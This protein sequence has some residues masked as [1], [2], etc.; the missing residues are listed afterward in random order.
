M[1]INNLISELNTW[2]LLVFILFVM[3]A[4]FALVNYIIVLIK[5]KNRVI[6]VKAS[7]YYLMLFVLAGLLALSRL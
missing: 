1:I 5:D 7:L 2:D 3:T 4:L 6:K